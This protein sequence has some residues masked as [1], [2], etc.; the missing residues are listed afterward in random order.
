MRESRTAATDCRTSGYR[1]EYRSVVTVIDGCPRCS[2]TDLTGMPASGPNKDAAEC[3]VSWILRPVGSPTR[4]TER[5]RHD[6]PSL[7]SASTIWSAPADVDEAPRRNRNLHPLDAMTRRAHQHV[8]LELRTTPQRHR[9]AHHPPTRRHDPRHRPH[10]HHQTR[11]TGRTME[12][13][14]H[15]FTRSRKASS[16]SS[17]QAVGLRGV[18]QHPAGHITRYRRAM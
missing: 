17:W 7:R 4:R 8:T 18:S 2:R 12:P 14:T 10:R 3:R 1:C 6:S 9:P 16:R 15:L 13:M 11:Q 5:T